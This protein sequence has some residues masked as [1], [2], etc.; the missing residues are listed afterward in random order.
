MT[1]NM[2]DGFGL[3][4]F[5]T[6]ALTT[7]PS[8]DNEV[9]PL[10]RIERRLRPHQRPQ[11]LSLHIFAGYSLRRDDVS[12][13]LTCHVREQTAAGEDSMFVPIEC[14]WPMQNCSEQ[15]ADS[16][17][18]HGSATPMPRCRPFVCPVVANV[19]EAS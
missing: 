12:C 7:R 15:S 3:G 11:H 16:A 1:T 17:W 14:D 4:A 6:V 8:C 18:A 10:V 9:N 13:F 19:V 2:A 5:Y